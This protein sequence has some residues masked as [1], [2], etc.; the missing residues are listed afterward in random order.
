[1]NVFEELSKFSHIR[2]YDH[3]HSYKCLD[4]DKKYTSVTTYKK[5]FIKPFNTSFW[6]NKK[7]KQLGITVKELRAEWDYKRILGTTRGTITHNYNEQLWQNK[8]FKQ[9]ADLSFLKGD[10]KEFFESIIT[11]RD[12]SNNFYNDYRKDLSLVRAELVVGDDDIDIA[13]QVDG[14]FYIDGKYVLLDYKTDKKFEMSSKYKMIGKLKHLDD[15][16]FTG[17]SLQTSIYKYIIEKNTNIKIDEIWIVW[18]NADLN[19]NYELIKLPY[20]K[21]ID[22]LWQK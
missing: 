16:Q 5:K 12:Y 22:T 1:M 11:L 7:S 14:L 19:S 4:T 15:C 8:V 21:E 6:L 3:N 13:G 20:L 10:T 17:Y 2:F 18:L 9:Q